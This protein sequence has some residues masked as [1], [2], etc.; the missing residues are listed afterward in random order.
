M[1]GKDV[2]KASLR[3]EVTKPTKREYLY[4]TATSQFSSF[5]ITLAYLEDVIQHAFVYLF[6]YYLLCFLFSFGDDFQS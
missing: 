4:P 6:L 1:S 3:L 5:W 2:A